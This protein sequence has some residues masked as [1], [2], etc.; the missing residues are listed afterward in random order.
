MWYTREKAS[1]ILT[2]FTLYSHPRFKRGTFS[3]YI[4]WSKPR[5]DVYEVKSI[6]E[7]EQIC[8]ASRQVELVDIGPSMA[9]LRFSR[10]GSDFKSEIRQCS[11]NKPISIEYNTSLHDASCE[12]CIGLWTSSKKWNRYYLKTV[13]ER[14]F[15]INISRIRF[16]PTY[17]S[18]RAFKWYHNR[19]KACL[20]TIVKSCMTNHCKHV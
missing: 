6:K 10:Q 20:I 11:L 17:L 5:I 1:L 8:F 18:K 15:E 2:S 9:H 7:A 16:F 14:Q 3:N 12:H 4:G 19:C 13:L